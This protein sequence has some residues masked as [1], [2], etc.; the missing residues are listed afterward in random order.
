MQCSAGGISA[1]ERGR[2]GIRPW[3]HGGAKVFCV[4]RVVG[5]CRNKEQKTQHRDFACKGSVCMCGVACEGGSYS[6]WSELVC[7]PDPEVD[8]EMKPT[9]AA[10]LN[11]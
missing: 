3:P 7:E 6:E 8:A 10:L 5:I 4:L 9:P 2:G 1:G 11:R